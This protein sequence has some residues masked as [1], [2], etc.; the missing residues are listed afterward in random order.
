MELIILVAGVLFFMYFVVTPFTA[1][2]MSSR[3]QRK[4]KEALE[5]VDQCMRDTFDGS[6][7]VTYKVNSSSLPYDMLMT[8]APNY[9]Y[10]YMAEN[11][12]S[13]TTT[14]VFERVD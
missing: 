1:L 2:S 7:I 13:G 4:R 10:K 9:G 6:P 5:D 8:E 3:D 12:A 14:V 11:T